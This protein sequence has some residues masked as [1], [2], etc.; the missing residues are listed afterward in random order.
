MKNKPGGAYGRL[1]III[2]TTLVTQISA[3][4]LYHENASICGATNSKPWFWA[5][6]SVAE[7]TYQVIDLSTSNNGDKWA[8]GGS[9]SKGLTT[10]GCH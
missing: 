3:S 10:F 2:I 1:L 5:Y 4:S 6:N 9:T 7:I 8:I